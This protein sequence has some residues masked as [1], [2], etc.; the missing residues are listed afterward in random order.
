[1]SLSAI[2]ID[3]N[4]GDINDLSRKL[5]RYCPQI[6][7]VAQCSSSALGIMKIREC[8]PEIVFLDVQMPGM[9]GFEMLKKLNNYD[10]TLIFVTAYERFAIRAFQVNAL[11]YIVKPVLPESLKNAVL[12]AI[13]TNRN[14]QELVSL[15]QKI[16]RMLA[17]LSSERIVLNTNRGEVP[18]HPASIIYF[19][20]AKN[21]SLVVL[22]EKSV[23]S[24]DK[25]LKKYQEQLT[26]HFCRI[27]KRFI[28]NLFRI[29]IYQPKGGNAIVILDNGDQLPVGRAYKK[30]FEHKWRNGTP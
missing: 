9:D 19:E 22:D 7:L 29:D 8:R 3:D 5:K 21:N 6:E 10:F 26:S 27:H 4:T 20:G 16:D 2:I 30:E 11:D 15:R 12:K 18:V 28:V 25:N 1:M 17:E 13:K 14:N 23:Y 24:F